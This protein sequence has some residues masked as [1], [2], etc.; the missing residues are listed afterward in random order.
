MSKASIVCSTK[1]LSQEHS[2]FVDPI[3]HGV[4][5]DSFLHFKHHNLAIYVVNFFETFSTHY[6]NSP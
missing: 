1:V 2:K 6:F 5:I 3:L 4:K